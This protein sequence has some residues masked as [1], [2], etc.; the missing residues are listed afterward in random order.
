[1]AVALIDNVN[2]ALMMLNQNRMD[3][4]HDRSPCVPEMHRHVMLANT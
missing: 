4:R 1:M 3:H 2:E